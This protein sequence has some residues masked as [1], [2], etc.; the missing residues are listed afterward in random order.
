MKLVLSAHDV[1]GMRAHTTSHTTSHA[2]TS[3]RSTEPQLLAVAASTGM[4]EHVTTCTVCK[5]GHF[6]FKWRTCNTHCNLD[7]DF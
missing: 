3:K 6:S 5:N 7:F 1:V 4:P 2:S